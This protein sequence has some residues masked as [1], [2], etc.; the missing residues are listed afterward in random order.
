VVH[1]EPDGTERLLTRYGAGDH[2]GELAVLREAARAATVVA[3]AEGVRGLVIDG[4]GI[5]A[6]LQ[7]RPTAAMAMLATLAERLSAH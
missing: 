3:E 4:Q 1:V 6:I 2:I 7:E 5:K